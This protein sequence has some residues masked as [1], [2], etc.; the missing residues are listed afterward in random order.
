MNN[1]IQ[2]NTEIIRIRYV[3][4]LCICCDKRIIKCKEINE[5]RFADIKYRNERCNS[6]KCTNSVCVLVITI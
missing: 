3:K 4:I 1:D 6:S 2:L 5:G